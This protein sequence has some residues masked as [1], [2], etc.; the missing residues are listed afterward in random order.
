MNGNPRAEPMP[1]LLLASQ[2]IFNLGFYSV[3][4]F[5]A[6]SLREDFGMGAMAVGIVLGARTFAQ[7]GL[8]FVGGAAADR[9]GARPVMI[10]GCLA[11]ISGYLL[12]IWASDFPLFLLGAVITGVGG[13][14]FSPALESLVG[15]A[16]ERR[17]ALQPRKTSLFALLV[18]FGEVGAVAGPLL[19]SILLQTGFDTA[20]L[21][22]SGVF[23]VMA[24]VFNAFLPATTASAVAPSVK[25]PGAAPPSDAWSCLREKRFVAFAAFYSVNLFAYNQLYFGLPIELE[26]SD[27]GLGALSAVF[28]YASILTITLQW[29][30]AGLMK[31][32]GPG[33][34]L[35][36][37]FAVQGLGFVAIAAMAVLPAPA[38]FPA[39]PA[40]LLVTALALGHMCVAPV[41]MDLVLEY[42][43]GRPTGAYYGLLASCGGTMVLLGN[44]ALAPLYEQATT[45]SLAAAAPWLVSAIFA[46]ASAALIH[47][48]LAAPVPAPRTQQLHPA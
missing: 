39:L 19:G 17:A 46:A 22:G 13:A 29:P 25:H 12:L 30:I 8:F 7:Q 42:A 45:P 10:A 3:V 4:P 27:A 24:V 37:G 16:E 6:V 34:A 21:A 28:A 47:R 11:R 36:V 26:R 1:R 40:F 14:L 20:L 44:V 5:L 9:W 15:G 2:L 38:A 33:A 23:A 32:K 31:R 41:A 43:A 18:I 48:F 35:A